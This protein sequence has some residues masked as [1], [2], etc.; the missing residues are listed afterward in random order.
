MCVATVTGFALV[1]LSEHCVAY[2]V[3][4]ARLMRR[5]SDSGEVAWPGILA[6]AKLLLLAAVGKEQRL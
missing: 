5:R 3:P 2:L 6:R 4:R 1:A